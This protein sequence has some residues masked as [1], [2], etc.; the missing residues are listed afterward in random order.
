MTQMIL[1]G[2]GYS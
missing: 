2:E 1:Y